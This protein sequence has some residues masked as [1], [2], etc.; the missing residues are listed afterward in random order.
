M[1]RL[2]LSFAERKLAM[3]GKRGTDVKL[4]STCHTPAASPAL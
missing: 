2:C 1:D 4:D 3:R